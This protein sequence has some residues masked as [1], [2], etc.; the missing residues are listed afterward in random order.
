VWIVPLRASDTGW[1]QLYEK[2]IISIG[3]A[4]ASSLIPVTADS[5]SIPA[6][7]R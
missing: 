5:P 4:L 3:F 7:T 6:I 1:K 2:F